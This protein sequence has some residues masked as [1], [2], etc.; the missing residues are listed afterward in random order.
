MAD[1]VCRGLPADW[2]NAWLAALGAIVLEPRLR[3]SWTNTPVPLAVLSTP[4]DPGPVDLLI[5]AWPD[6]SRLDG[7]PTAET[8]GDAPPMSRQVPVDVF[9]ERARAARSHPDSWTISSTLTDLVVYDSGTVGHAPL[10]PKGPGTI[11]HLHHRL[12]KTW[13]KV[14]DPAASLRA[15]LDG[16]GVRVEDNGLGFDVGRVTS[17]ADD[18]SKFVDPVIEVL[19]FFGLALL[20]VRG[21][22]VDERL[23][24]A[25]VRPVRQRCWVS[26]GEMTW[27]V[28]DVPLGRDG[29]DALLDM[30]GDRPE[31][32][33]RDIGVF[34][35]FRS[36]PYEARGSA[37]T[38]VAY[39]SERL[40]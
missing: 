32:A 22:G 37:D 15:S 10:D 31:C 35:A 39:G 26:G 33:R 5:G 30:V 28:W 9:I 21:D 17:L 36:V 6:K 38:T 24:G 40:F 7:M 12:V 13:G 19:A 11:K 34:G 8:W 4:S 14:E 25:R 16:C 20:P 29:V 3:L 27:P 18:S 2:L 23:L 1:Y